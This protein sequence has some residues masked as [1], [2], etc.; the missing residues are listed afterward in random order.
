[1]SILSLNPERKGQGPFG[2]AFGCGRGLKAR[3]DD[4]EA[5]VSAWGASY[6]VIY[7]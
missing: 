5:D 4:F 7:E 2:Q 1:M 6:E 3:R